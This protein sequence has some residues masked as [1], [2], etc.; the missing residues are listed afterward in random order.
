MT[1]DIHPRNSPGDL[2]D[3]F[4]NDLIMSFSNDF[5]RSPIEVMVNELTV[6]VKGQDCVEH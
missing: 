4:V 1:F 6:Y 3:G 5:A 2:A